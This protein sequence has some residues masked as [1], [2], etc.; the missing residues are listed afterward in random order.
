MHDTIPLLPF[1]ALFDFDHRIINELIPIAGIILA[2]VIT[3]SAMY[4][5]HHQKKM[6]HETTRL[7]LERGQ[8]LSPELIATLSNEARCSRRGGRND[9]RQGLILMAV[10]AGLILFMSR[11]ADELRFVGAIPGFIGVTL[12]IYGLLEPMFSRKSREPGDGNAGS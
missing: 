5:S 12:F 8:P 2:G 3:V 6:L 4:F 7:A 10:G 11:I 9:I 1:A